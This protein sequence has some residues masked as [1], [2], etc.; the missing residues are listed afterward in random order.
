M[1]TQ[2]NIDIR[3]A[4]TYLAVETSTLT[5]SVSAVAVR[6][7]YDYFISPYLRAHPNVAAAPLGLGG[8]DHSRS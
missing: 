6:H 7:V 2:A 8:D 1:I 3:M 5:E 4:D